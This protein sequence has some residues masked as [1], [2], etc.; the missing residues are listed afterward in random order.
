MGPLEVAGSES[1]EVIGKFESM[2]AHGTMPAFTHTCLGYQRH[3]APGTHEV[4]FIR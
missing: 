4:D 2:A 3:D 1:L